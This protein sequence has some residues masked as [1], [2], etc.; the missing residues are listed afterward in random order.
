[1]R[2]GVRN[3]K[4]RLSPAAKG[5]LAFL[6]SCLLAGPV[7]AAEGAQR[8]DGEL[9]ATISRTAYGVP[10]IRAGDIES[11]AFGFAYAFAEDNLCTI[12]DSYVTVAGQRSRYFGPDET[13]TFAG[14]GSVLGN[15]DSD[16]FYSA[17]NDSGVIERLI[18]TPPPNGPL[19]AVKRGVRGYVAGYNHYLRE[20]GVERLP[21]RRCRGADWVRPIDELDVYRRFYQLGSLASSGVA[22]P[23]I[24]D[25]APLLGGAATASARSAQADAIED[26]EAGRFESPFPLELGSNAYGLGAEATRT[27]SGMLLGNPHFPWDGAER[28]YQAHLTIPGEVDVAGGALYGVP[29]INIGHTD[30][31]AWSHT[32]ATAWRFTPFELTLAP[33]DPYSYIVDGE[34]VPMERQ[35]LT[36]KALG[37]GGELAERSRTLYSTRYGPMVT[38]LLGLP[39]FPWTPLKAY[40]L[41]DVNASNFR[42]LNHFYRNNRAQSVREYDRIQRTIQGI[43]WVNSIAADSRGN[44]YYS[45]DGSV[46]NV[47]DAKARACSG[48]L[49]AVTFTVL[50]LPTLD[51]SRSECA[52]DEDHD[53]AYPGLMPASDLPRLFRRDYVTNGNDSHWLA[54]PEQPLEGYPRIVGIEGAPVTLRT[55]L[56]LLQVQQRIAGSDGLAGKRF[57]LRQLTR[58][59]LSNRQYAGELWRDQ[60]VGLCRATPVLIGSGEIFPTPPEACDALAGWDLHDNLGSS[61]AILFRRFAANLLGRLPGLP[62]GTQGELRIDDALIYTTPFD[63]ANPVNTPSGLNTASPLVITALADAITD[64]RS[65]GIP[66]D[67]PLRGYQ[68]EIRGGRKIPIHGGPGDFGVFNAI[69]ASWRPG[70][71]GYT[72][73]PHGTSFITAVAFTPEAGCPVEARTFVTY[74]QSENQSSPHADDYTRAFSRKDW[75]EVPFCSAEI[76][77]DPDLEVTRV[78]SGGG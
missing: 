25:A 6:A 23:G 13:W 55:R 27:G 76:R 59:A 45:M 14:N 21:D 34:S 32:V 1:M 30:N 35:T 43:P 9:E 72:N 8:S 57:S 5:A 11:L 71:G 56:G 53:A 29:L 33:G 73:I 28:L 22:I 15:L 49:G 24:V 66:L 19:P 52:W 2:R 60:L 78:D 46:P 10:H 64:L 37:A 31:L 3:G 17:I 38:S 48:L 50:G 62:T 41:G 67:A 74:S 16:F 58:V 36:V 20:T 65:A 44:A 7:G 51:G 68:Y 47:S 4:V 39:L 70:E 18:R 77:A 40:A 69:G 42:Y 63:P 75:N 26:L 54:N 12:A 61:G